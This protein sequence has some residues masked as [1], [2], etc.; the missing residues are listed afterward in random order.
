MFGAKVEITLREKGL[1]VDLVHIT[2]G[3]KTRYEPKHSEVVRINPNAQIP[4]LVNKD[5]ELY[6]STQISECIEDAWPT[7]RL[8]P[9][10]P[11]ARARASCFE[12]EADE[13][14]YADITKLI[15]RAPDS[16]EA[17]SRAQDYQGKANAILRSQPY[18]AGVYG[19]ADI[20]FFMASLFADPLG[21]RIDASHD[22]LAAWIGRVGRRPAVAAVTQEML[23]YMVGA[24]LPAARLSER[25]EPAASAQ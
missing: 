2:F 20:A 14:F 22:A 25:F 8:W 6:G 1:S 23:A 4:V 13:V 21:V 3:Y 16:A 24:G 9:A 17:R 18:L 11:R 5:L 10:G 19:Y 7:R 15:N 12:H